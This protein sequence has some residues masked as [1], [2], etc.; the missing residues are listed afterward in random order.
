[1]ISPRKVLAGT[2]LQQRRS[3]RT[4]QHFKQDTRDII[5]RAPVAKCLNSSQSLIVVQVLRYCYGY[6]LPAMLRVLVWCEYCYKYVRSV[7]ATCII[8]VT[9]EEHTSTAQQQQSMLLYNNR[10]P[11]GHVVVAV[12]HMF[13]CVCCAKLKH[14][15][16]YSYDTNHM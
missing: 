15:A 1:M 5:R 4:E 10:S 7:S 13:V 8:V 9:I 3:T 12:R 2:T 11:Q 14:L 16:L 6:L